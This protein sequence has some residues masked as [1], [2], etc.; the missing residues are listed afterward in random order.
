MINNL[1]RPEAQVSITVYCTSF[2]DSFTKTVV[3]S[4]LQKCTSVELVFLTSY[5]SQ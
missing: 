2:C 5:N 4:A 3:A 1:C